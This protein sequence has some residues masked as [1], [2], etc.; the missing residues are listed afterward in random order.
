MFYVKTKINEECTI[1]TD[2][3]D[4]NVF[5]VCPGCGK[6]HGVDIVDLATECGE[7]DLCGTSVYCHECS[8]ERQKAKQ[9]D[10]Q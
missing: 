8:V 2:I 4:E 1:R 6:E 10:K 9:E 5:T 3:T 7:F